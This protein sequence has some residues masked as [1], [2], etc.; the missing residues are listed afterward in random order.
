MDFEV[1]LALVVGFFFMA[2]SWGPVALHKPFS[3][4]VCPPSLLV[5]GPFVHPV[6]PILPELDILDITKTSPFRFFF[7]LAGH[8]QQ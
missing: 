1:M 2:E 6:Q 3:G 5:L 7:A 4:V 8:L